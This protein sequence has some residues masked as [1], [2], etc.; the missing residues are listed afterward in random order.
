MRAWGFRE[1]GETVSDPKT[2]TLYRVFRGGCW[3]DFV[4]SWVRA[5]ARDSDAPSYRNSIIGFRCARG[6]SER[7]VKP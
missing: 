3:I 7:K 1:E 6:G 2:D 5:A 4:P